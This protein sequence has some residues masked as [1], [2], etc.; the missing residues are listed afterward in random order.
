MSVTGILEELESLEEVGVALEDWH[1]V[2][3]VGDVVERRAFA[4]LGV[5]AAR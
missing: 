2:L 3:A 5:S 4:I 1:V